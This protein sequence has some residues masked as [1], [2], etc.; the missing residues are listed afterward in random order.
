MVNRVIACVVGTAALAGVARAD[1]SLAFAWGQSS[2]EVLPG[3]TVA[4]PLYLT[5]TLTGSSSSILLSENGVSSVGVRVTRNAAQLP[6]S[7]AFLT[8]G[9]LSINTVD[10]FDS[11]DPIF[12]PELAV[13]P[14]GNLAQLLMFARDA[15]VVGSPT[16]PSVRR[17]LLGTI[18]FSAG[19]VVGETTVFSSGDYDLDTSDTVTWQNFQVLDDQITGS[20]ISITTIV[21]APGSASGLVMVGLLAA[22][23]RR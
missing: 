3:A 14:S 4:V 1:V 9:G 13:S 5:E 22:R 7:P 19:S 8:L 11:S 18:T 20:S 23:R 2:V 10:F 6:T 12:G 16:S 21:P 17:L 15:G